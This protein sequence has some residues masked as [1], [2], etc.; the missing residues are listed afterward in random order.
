ML[1]GTRLL[2]F[3]DDFAVFAN[4]FDETMRRKNE[5]FALVDNLGLNIHPTKG[6]HT[7]TQVGEHLGMGFNFEHGVFRAPVT[8]LKDISVFA[9]NILCTPV[10]N[11]R[12]V[13]V[14]AL[15]SLEGKVQFLHLAILVAR[16][17]LREI[18]DVVS[19]AQSWS[20]TVLLSKQLKRD[21]EW[22]RKVPEKHNDAPIFKLIETS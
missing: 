11:K 7:A 21:L 19:T 3:V 12:C 1:T 10:A 13:P 16:F 18:H 4:G 15:A 22:W 9:K 5:T 14:K 17:Y 20:G 8:K 2:P 6:Y